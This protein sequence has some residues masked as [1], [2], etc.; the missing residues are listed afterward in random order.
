MKHMFFFKLHYITNCL[1]Q[2]GMQTMCH[3][4]MRR[5][6]TQENEPM[7]KQRAKTTKAG[8]NRFTQIKHYLGQVCTHKNPSLLE[9]EAAKP[10]SKSQKKKIKNYRITVPPY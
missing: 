5:G 1:R 2:K 10:K 7:G 3:K 4:N 6:N 8:E 9:T